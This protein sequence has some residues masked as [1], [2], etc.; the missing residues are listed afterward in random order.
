VFKKTGEDMNT[1]LNFDSNIKKIEFHSNFPFVELGD[2]DSM[3]AS[4]MFEASIEVTDGKFGVMPVTIDSVGGDVYALQSIIDMWEGG[5]Y[6]VCTFARGKALSAGA[7][8]LA[9]GTPGL[10]FISPRCTYMLHDMSVNLSG[11]AHEVAHGTKHVENLQKR[12]FNEMAERCGQK[13]DF[14]LDLLHKNRHGEVYL[15][16][17]EVVKYGVADFIGVPTIQREITTTTRIFFKDNAVFEQSSSSGLI[18]GKQHKVVG[19]HSEEGHYEEDGDDE[20]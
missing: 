15:S 6:K 1:E 13:P 3:A 12:I 9:F 17:E 14:F 20:E 7:I 8:A 5:N 19:G 18:A 4:G 11:K 10:R 16:P 2:F